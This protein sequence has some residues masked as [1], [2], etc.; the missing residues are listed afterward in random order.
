MTDKRYWTNEK[1]EDHYRKYFVCYQGYKTFTLTLFFIYL[2]FIV[3]SIASFFNGRDILNQLPS[4]TVPSNATVTGVLATI[5]VQDITVSLFLIVI[6]IWIIPVVTIISMIYLFALENY[7]LPYPVAIGIAM[8]NIAEKKANSDEYLLLH[9]SSSIAK[10]SAMLKQSL[11]AQI[12]LK[13]LPDVK[14]A[15]MSLR[16]LQ[17][18]FYRYIYLLSKEDFK[19]V[20]NEI[21][22]VADDLESYNIPLFLKDM[23]TLEKKVEA[24]VPDHLKKMDM[25]SK[26]N[27]YGGIVEFTDKHHNTILV[28][29]AL[30]NIV[31]VI[32]GIIYLK[33]IIQ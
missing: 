16:L 25:H 21:I 10:D 23:D 4:N 27:W 24:S 32:L 26:P 12:G 13:T 15:F 5:G 2:F 31:I 29:I 14:D 19:A 28:V 20:Y 6:A 33:T 1:K 11:E 7:R 30:L 18:S 17:R 9:N 3:M 22:K 8:K